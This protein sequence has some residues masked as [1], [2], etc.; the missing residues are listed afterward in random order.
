[1][2]ISGKTAIISGGASGLGHATALMLYEAGANVVIT[3]VNEEKGNEIVSKMEDRGLFVK[4]DILSEEDI[5]NA[6]K[7]AVEKFGKIHILVNTAGIG[8]SMRTIGKNGI[9][10]MERFKRILGVNLIG[11]FCISSNAAWEMTKN[12]PEDGECGVII[13]TASTAAYEGQIG[14]VAYA[15]SK[16]G[17][18]GMTL[19]MARDLARYGIRVVTIAPGT[20]DTP[21]LGRL[22][23]EV[24]VS[25][26]K[27]VPFPSRLGK[28]D[29]YAKLAKTI[30]ELPYV[31]GEVIR[32]DGAL[33]MGPQ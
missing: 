12:K 5:K 16:A 15:S 18:V 25:L 7:K 31:N 11:T 8:G 33:R 29:E 2:N 3:D 9:Y 1:M 20:F 19:T 10:D 6:V 17:L 28:P 13:N 30:I 21:L 32:L 23:Q 4:T 27:Q 24:L 26:G 14:Q 22:S